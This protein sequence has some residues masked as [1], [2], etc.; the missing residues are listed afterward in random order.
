MEKQNKKQK[1]NQTHEQKTQK[2]TDQKKTGWKKPGNIHMF[3]CLE[4]TR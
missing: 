4:F 3:S 1:P 2:P